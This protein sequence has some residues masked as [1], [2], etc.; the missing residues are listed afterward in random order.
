MV[1]P[2]TRLALGCPGVTTHLI[3]ACRALLPI[4]DDCGG[5]HAARGPRALARRL[6]SAARARRRLPD[7]V[8]VVAVLL[9]ERG[10]TVD[11]S[12]VAAWGAMGLLGLAAASALQLSA[13]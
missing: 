3:G 7:D 2:E 11:A 1:S 12:T 6:A 8:T 13:W 5:L 9:D 10:S 4:A